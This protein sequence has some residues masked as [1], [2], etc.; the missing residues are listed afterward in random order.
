MP[1]TEGLSLSNGV[2]VVFAV[3]FAVQRIIEFLDPLFTSTDPGRKRVITGIIA[4]FLGLIA[5][6]FGHLSV[7]ATAPS[8]GTP[9]WFTNLIVTGFAI[10]AGTDG[11]NSVLKYAQYSKTEKSEDVKGAASGLRSPGNVRISSDSADDPQSLE[12][13][14]A[15]ARRS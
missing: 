8:S 9:D 7:F 12:E 4:T 15:L 10:G 1:A 13:A 2:A 3:G 5:T 14:R 11:I 6:A